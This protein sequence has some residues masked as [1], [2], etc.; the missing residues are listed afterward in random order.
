MAR[1]RACS[2]NSSERGLMSLSRL[3]EEDALVAVDLLEEEGA[4][5]SAPPHVVVVVDEDREPD[6]T[7]ALLVGH[8]FETRGELPLEAAGIDAGGHDNHQVDI[9][10][11]IGVGLGKIRLA[12]GTR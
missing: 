2:R 12:A 3:S 4:D 9:G 1:S 5:L 6:R 8:F 11:T 7:L 10:A